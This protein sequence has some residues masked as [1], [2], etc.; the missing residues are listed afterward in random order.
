MLHSMASHYTRKASPYYWLR[1]QR[2]DGTWGDKSSGIRVEGPIHPM[3]DYFTD[4]RCLSS[5]NGAWMPS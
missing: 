2:D 3:P 4:K 1:Y 5:S